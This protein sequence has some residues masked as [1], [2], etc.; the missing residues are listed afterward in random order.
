MA[1]YAAFKY[2]SGTLYG[3][4]DPVI[5]P[6][7]DGDVTWIAS[8]K[9]DGSTPVN[10]ASYMTNF[11]SFRG[12]E[13]YI[14]TGG[15]GFETI[16]PGKALLTLDNS[17]LRYD[18]YNTLSPIYPYVVPGREVQVSVYI[19]ET[20]ITEEIIAGF[21][22]DIQPVSGTEEVQITVEDGMRQLADAPY[23][24]GLMYS[25]TISDAINETLS[26]AN[27]GSPRNIQSTNQPLQVFDPSD[28]NCLEIIRGL[29]HANMGTFFIDRKGK[30]CFYPISYT[31]P[32]TTT[33]TSDL[34]NREIRVPQP[35][36]T[37]RN[38]VTVIANRR[39]KRPNSVIWTFAGI[40][41]I[42]AGETRP[43]AA[44][45][46]KSDG[47]AQPIPNID[48]VANTLSNNTGTNVSSQFIVTFT[49]LTASECTFTVKND[50]SATGF[51]LWLR[52]TGYEI[53]SSPLK[54]FVTDPVSISFYKPRQFTL[55]NKWLQDRNF[56]EQYAAVACAHLNDPQ[57][58]PIIQIDQRP[59]LQY[60]FDLMEHARLI[61]AS[62]SIDATS[63]IY[64]IRHEWMNDTG[65]NVKTTIYLQDVM[66]DATVVTPDPFIPVG[67]GGLND[68]PDVPFD[69]QPIWL[70]PWIPD[71]DYPVMPEIGDFCLLT[72]ASETQEFAVTAD[73]KRLENK[74]GG[75]REA[76]VW[77]PCT[78]RAAN[79]LNKSVLNVYGGWSYEDS[80]SDNVLVWKYESENSWWHVDAINSSKAVLAS[81]TLSSI[82]N[83]PR[84]ATFAPTTPLEVAGFRI[85]IDEEIG[86]GTGDILQ[87]GSVNPSS[88]DGTTINGLTINNYYAIEASGGPWQDDAT[89]PSTWSYAFETKPSGIWRVVGGNAYIG[90]VA[91][92]IAGDLLATTRIN[93]GNY[94]RGFFKA[95]GTSC[96][97][98]A[99]D[100]ENGAEEWINGGSLNY[101]LRESRIAGNKLMTINN[102][103]LQNIC[104]T[105]IL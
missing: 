44:I 102:L 24:R 46:N 9:W 52:I 65:Q 79:A 40:I 10:E 74:V 89:L 23:N 15:N 42:A 90:F 53:V 93:N 63:E 104:G 83:Y 59:T 80:T 73:N 70:D 41:E 95:I 81:A 21:I 45:F 13:H 43:F 48:Y 103:S 77:Y 28:E 100:G 35:W 37:V 38:N 55:D 97:F 96:G 56:A 72:D 91:G 86:Y 29:A 25:I 2:H 87:T 94:S 27:L 101:I 19:H 85:W 17:D 47:I 68:L 26:V 50:T 71:T 6:D 51:L 30:A 82:T 88:S 64:G 7:G 54:S 32:T 76:F 61:V 84:F 3:T 33:L 4:G 12:A 69:N 66:Y 11:N 49:D 34:I 14:E 75:I 18:P 8:I 16:E 92:I 78:L 22:T 67:G 60:S 98:R 31:H 5:I 20:K 57:K 99:Y 62:R 36:E 58:N 39:A 1:K 105:G